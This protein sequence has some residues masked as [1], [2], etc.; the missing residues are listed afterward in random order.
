MTCRTSGICLLGFVILVVLAAAG[1]GQQTSTGYD[2][3]Q[4]NQALIN[5][6]MQALLTCNGLFV[7]NRTLDQIYGAELKLDLMP[8]APPSEV[9]IDR[10]RKTVTVGEGGAIPVMRAV[11]REGLGC[12]VMGPEQTFADIDRL[13]ILKMPAPQGDASRMPWPD[14]DLI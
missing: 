3:H 1:S 7:S 5:A 6:G 10:E 4:S 13:A 14:G 12:V 9:K 11:H 2:Y 8:L